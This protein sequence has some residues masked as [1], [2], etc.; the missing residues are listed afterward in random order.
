VTSVIASAYD[1]GLLALA[2]LGL[3]FVVY[4]FLNSK[5]GLFIT[6][7]LLAI[8]PPA[9][10]EIGVV[11][12]AYICIFAGTVGGWI[13]KKSWRQLPVTLTRYSV[14]VILTLAV[15]SLLTALANGVG[16]SHW[17]RGIIPFAGLFLYFVSGTVIQTSKDR[18]QLIFVFYVTAITLIIISFRE[19]IASINTALLL[20]NFWIVRENLGFGAYQ[21]LII[22]IP[23]FAAGYAF[24]RP[25]SRP[26]LHYGVLA[27]ASLAS[28]ITL[29]RS[30]FL[31]MAICLFVSLWLYA[32]THARR[33][34][35]LL[36][37]KLV[38]VLMLLT[39]LLTISPLRSIFDVFSA[40]VGVRFGQLAEQDLS[41]NVRVLEFNEVKKY[42]L[43]SP[44]V[45]KGLGFQYEF[46]RGYLGYWQGGY[47]HNIISYFALTMGIIGVISLMGFLFTVYRDFS[48][49][50]SVYRSYSP[51]DRA[52]LMGAILYI[53]S[54][55]LYV[56]FQS[57]FRH[58][59]F[60]TTLSIMLGAATSIKSVVTGHEGSKKD[61]CNG[62]AAV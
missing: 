40:G 41:E 46:I 19:G 24:E 20:K 45:G 62:E 57:V 32:R 25:Q 12:V 47:T 23:L 54:L 60:F 52:F 43:E 51:A 55:L 37:I 53:V 4:V 36:V 18:E 21:P 14:V 10:K 8:V 58:V 42:F 49:K 39:G 15:I 48:A 56:Q 29:L 9:P 59:S 13:V 50:L 3:L 17:I 1:P 22:G 7:F 27:V 6:I 5:A 2:P 61:E 26:W 38:G 35:V 28:L 11:E 31:V 33:Q 34:V 44:L 16:V 30:V